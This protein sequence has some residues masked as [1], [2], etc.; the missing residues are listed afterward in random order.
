M[1]QTRKKLRRVSPKVA[2]AIEALRSALGSH[3]PAKFQDLADTLAANGCLIEDI[4]E[5]AVIL[6][7]RQ[8]WEQKISDD[9]LP[10][11]MRKKLL[12]ATCSYDELLTIAAASGD[13]EAQALLDAGVPE[14][15]D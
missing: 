6:D 8:L 4:Q 3:R 10:R 11:L 5:A 13:Q 12:P 7:E 1:R 9:I 15:L 2:A 14:L